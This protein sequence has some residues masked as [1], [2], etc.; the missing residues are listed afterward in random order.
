MEL[1]DLEKNLAEDTLGM[2]WQDKNDQTTDRDMNG[3][4]THDSG[5]KFQQN[6]WQFSDEGKST[7]ECFTIRFTHVKWES[8]K[9]T[10]NCSGQC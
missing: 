9:S 8:K 3:E 10:Q 4:V 2:G 1:E 5:D 6:Q 7:E